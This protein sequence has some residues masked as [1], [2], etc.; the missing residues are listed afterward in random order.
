MT[1]EVMSLSQAL[2]V[3]ALVLE[4]ELENTLPEATDWQWEVKTA[5]QVITQA[6][7]RP[8]P[9]EFFI[10]API[11]QRPGRRSTQVINS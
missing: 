2:N 9:G 8:D 5:H 6:I 1:Q 7:A 4:W 11:R 10:A 3:A